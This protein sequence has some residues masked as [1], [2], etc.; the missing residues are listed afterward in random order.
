MTSILS[1]YIID[2]ISVAYLVRMKDYSDIDSRDSFDILTYFAFAMLFLM[3]S[4][5][6][7]AILIKFKHNK[8]YKN[9]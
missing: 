6:L 1:F 4:S 2:Y 8:N 3:G 9:D 5:V 7:L